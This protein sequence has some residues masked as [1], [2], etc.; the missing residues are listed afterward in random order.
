MPPRT[1]PLQQMHS[2]FDKPLFAVETHPGQVVVRKR[3]FFTPHRGRFFFTPTGTCA[4]AGVFAEIFSL[5]SYCAHPVS[6]HQSNPRLEEIVC[7]MMR[8]P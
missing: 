1:I 5:S 7:A 6:P 8:H 2:Q 3:L 4:T